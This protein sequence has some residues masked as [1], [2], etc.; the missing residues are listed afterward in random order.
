[1]T[2]R[3]LTR[4]PR[5]AS[6]IIPGRR[7]QGADQLVGVGALAAGRGPEHRVDHAAGAAGDHG[8][9]AY[10]RVAGAAVVAGALAVDRQVLGGVGD[11]DGGAVDRADQAAVPVHPA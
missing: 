8:E 7:A 6:R 10:Q 1:L 9:Q 11:A 3:G 2:T 5:A 4:R